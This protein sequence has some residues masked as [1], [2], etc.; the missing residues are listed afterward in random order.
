ML[1]IGG[2]SQAFAKPQTGFRAGT[3]KVD[4]T[5]VPASLLP[6]DSIRDHLFV[7]AIV[8]T[9][10]ASCAVLVGTDLA[11]LPGAIAPSAIKRA[12]AATGCAAENFVISA[13]HTH[14]GYT[15]SF[16]D[17]TGEP[18]DKRV[19]DAIV[20]AITQAHASMRSVRVGYGTVNLDI[21]VNRDLLVDGR[22]LQGPNLTGPSDKTL[23]IMEFVG[24][25]DQP[26]GAY[27]NYAMHPINFF[28]SGVISADVP[29]D[30]SDYIERQFGGNM[31]A[32]FAQGASGDQ[33]PALTRPLLNLISQ[34]T[35]APGRGDMRLA[36]PNPWVELSNERNGNA[37]LTAALAIPVPADRTQA[38]LEAIQTTGDLVRAEGTVMGEKIVDAM[39]FGI[40][41]LARDGQIGAVVTS[42]QCPGRDRLDHA[43]PVREGNLPPYADGAPVTVR[44]GM[45]RIGD[46]YIATVDGEVYSEIATQLKQRAPATKLMMTTLANGMANLGY[47]YSNNASDHLTFQVIG[48]RLKP[49]CAEDKIV[50]TGLEQLR[51]LRMSQ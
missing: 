5:P 38:Y 47:I 48:S 6:G 42:L 44:Q 35:G 51:R 10:G 7:R 34:R 22:W 30:A 26:I 43:D 50:A 32:V 13:T 40:T 16:G 25:D 11:G 45:L 28:L 20:A 15:R 18:N 41:D 36:R 29:G 39:R 27:I 14:S 21:N 33:N 8:L 4:I 9:N 49:G 37:R 31:V 12:S 3:A 1:A 23:A 17:P 46:V 19:V 24:D 2:S